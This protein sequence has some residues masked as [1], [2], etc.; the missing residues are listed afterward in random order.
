MAARAPSRR[1][2][3]PAAPAA[4][5]ALPPLLLL[6]L[7]LLA[8]PAARAQQSPLTFSRL[9]PLT[10]PSPRAFSTVVS[11]ATHLVFAGGRAGSLPDSVPTDMTVQPQTVAPLQSG[12]TGLPLAMMASCSVPEDM[13]GLMPG[14][15]SAFA[16][17]GYDAAN[18]LQNWLFV[19]NASGWVRLPTPAMAPTARK[20]A[21]LVFLRS[22]GAP[23]AYCLVLFGGSTAVA[24]SQA[25]ST[26]RLSIGAAPGALTWSVVATNGVVPPAGLF[27]HSAAAA[28]DGQSM[29]L[30]GGTVPA[31]GA[32]SGETYQLATLGYSDGQTTVSQM[33][34]LAYKMN[35]FGS[36]TF[37]TTA[38]GFPY[39]SATS[40]SQAITNYTVSLAS[41][42]SPTQAYSLTTTSTC[43]VTYCKLPQTTNPCGPT[44]LI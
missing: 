37:Q 36:S 7:L 39:G 24:A 17:G 40:Y 20:G 19:F 11:N 33:V 22:C 18:A 3:P 21:S 6:L 38:G 16:F 44:S 26:W 31:S 43:F 8:L 1:P 4:A 42:A 25:D 32:A 41:T 13:L 23:G 14:G 35:T 12:A 9:V 2:A 28:A 5:A 10:S 27:G 34:N 30:F 29:V 15:Y